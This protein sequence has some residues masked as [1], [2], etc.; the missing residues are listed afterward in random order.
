MTARPIRVAILDDYQRVAEDCADWKS[1]PPEVEVTVFRDTLADEDA[2]A[3]R[4]E[5]F[6]ILAVTRE[7]T[8]FSRSL[9][10]RLPNL[11][12][13]ATSG[14]RNAAIDMAAARELGITVCGTATLGYPTAELAWGLIIALCRH[15][16]VED[17]A[18]HQGGGWQ[19]TVGVGLRGKTLGVLGLGKLGGQV[20]AIGKA[21]GMEV[22]AWSRNLTEARCAEVGVRRVE[23]D[24]LFSGADMVT[25]HLVLGER[26][27]GLVGAAELAL[28]KPTAYL[29][30]TSR[31]PIV[32]EAALADALA[33]RR[34]A[35]AA[36][37]VYSREPLPADSR[38]RGL[39]N[40][41][42]TPHLGY[43]TRENLELFFGETVENI[44]A[45]L[46][47]APVRVL[48]AG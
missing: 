5:P 10:Q 44:A 14:M 22:V 18:M 36:I 27:R 37:D 42:L 43:V 1:L 35:G 47:G 2:L 13:I 3:R 32:D 16:A 30:N 40:V 11:K 31:G 38:L 33:A 20:A 17:R 12:L 28:M 48:N 46:K 21:F 25:I 24:A 26:T 29:V 39:D 6:R 7:R 23:K 45:F 34:I 41:L 4:L 15:I 19:T 8:L 9:L